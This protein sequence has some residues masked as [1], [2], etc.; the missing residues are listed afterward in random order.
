MTAFFKNN[1]IEKNE[2]VDMSG[3]TGLSQESAW[4]LH[5]V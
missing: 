4:G 2:I 1:E 3:E 5:L